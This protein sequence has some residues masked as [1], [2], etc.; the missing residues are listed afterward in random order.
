MFPHST[1]FQHIP[2]FEPYSKKK[3]SLR[4][5]FRLLQLHRYHLAAGLFLLSGS[6][7][8]RRNTTDATC[9]ATLW[10]S[11]ADNPARSLANGGPLLAIWLVLKGQPKGKQPGF[12]TGSYFE[13]PT[14]R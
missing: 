4:N 1:I 14:L 3:S 5:A 2:L 12:W 11:E 6:V 9:D 13:I 8:D 10:A 7:E